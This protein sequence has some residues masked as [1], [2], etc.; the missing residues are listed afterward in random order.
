L[1][2][3]ELTGTLTPAVDGA[4]QLAVRGLGHF[5]LTVDGKTVLDAAIAPEGADPIESF[6]VPP[7]RRVPVDLIAGAPVQV[8]LRQDVELAGLPGIFVSFALCYSEPIAPADQLIDEAVALAAAAD[9]AI[10]VVGTTEEVESEG[11]DRQSLALPG[12]Q[13]ELVS[14]VAAANPRTVVVV[15]SGSPVE[16][17]WENDVASVLLTWF[18]GQ[19]GGAALAD[20]LL[21]AAEPGGRLPTTWPRRAADCPVWENVPTDGVLAYDEGVFIGYRGWQRSAVE[22]MYAFGHGLGYTEWSY[23]SL[24]V[25]PGDG[26]GTAVVG[27]RNAG[28][29]RGREVVQ[30]YLGPADSDPE[31]PIRWLAGFAVVEADPGDT[32][33]VEIALPERAAQI[34]DATKHGWRTVGGQYTLEAAHS[35]EDRRL[36]TSMDV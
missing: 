8:T 19:E 16:L 36:T 22:P 17:P 1:A 27:L 12:R 28:A 3:V 18:P 34:W 32:V 13:D 10:V 24:T 15:N 5:A 14:R 21:G 35:I 23:D 2:A 31:R 11:F 25:R 26:L 33:T 20:V 7:E 6:L 4:H 9:V 29:R 30:V